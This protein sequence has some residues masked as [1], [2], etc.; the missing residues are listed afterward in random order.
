MRP[1]S[2]NN[3]RLGSWATLS[4][5]IVIAQKLCEEYPVAESDL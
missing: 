3:E 4:L 1:E 5:S 2:R